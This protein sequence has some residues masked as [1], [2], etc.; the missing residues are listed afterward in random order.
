M[1]LLPQGLGNSVWYKSFFSTYGA[2][3]AVSVSSLG[4]NVTLR[5]EARPYGE[6]A[7]V[8]DPLLSL[9]A[10]N[11]QFL[12]PNS[13]SLAKPWLRRLQCPNSKAM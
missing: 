11:K 7:A 6:G 12:S 10:L 3:T 9:W 5:S 1:F 4:G 2:Q 13:A 8:S